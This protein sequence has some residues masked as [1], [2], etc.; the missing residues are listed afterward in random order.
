MNRFAASVIILTAGLAA[1][2]SSNGDAGSPPPAVAG[3]SSG[4]AGAT[5]STA[6]NASAG[7][8]SAGTASGG[9]AGERAA[10]SGG[11]PNANAGDGGGG[12]SFAGAQSQA[13]VG[14][15]TPPAAGSGNAGGAANAAGSGGGPN[16]GLSYPYVFAVFND[17]AAVSDLQI[18]TSKDALNF[19][20]L[21]D[22]GYVGPSGYL[23]DPSIMKHTDG[24]FYV[25][26]TTPPTL[27]C[28]GAETSFAIASSSDLKK[29][30]TV[31]QVPCGIPGTTNVWAPEWF[32]D[33]DGSV[34]ILVT[35]DN[36]TYHYE[37]TDSTLTKFGAGTAIGIAPYIDTFVVKIAGTYHALAKGSAYIEHATA[38]SLNGPWTFV[39]KGDWAGWGLHKEAPALIDLGNGVW[40][41]YFDAGSTGHE[42]SSDSSDNFKTWTAP[43]GL[44]TVGNAISHGTVI[45]AD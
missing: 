2:S 9:S 20:L 16:I 7:T 38:S 43:K 29:W 40:R 23:R 19:T 6:G 32:K 1:C 37:A 34:H 41:V 11:A 15:V 21:S 36:K 33:D 30:T 24:K 14:G 45:H 28:C 12:V 13:G 4:A 18:Y 25:A 5:A 31:T 17:S 39:D 42:M 22:T 10:G 8:S 26:F 44:P 27:G 35:I 3:S